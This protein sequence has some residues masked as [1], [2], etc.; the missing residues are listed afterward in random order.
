MTIRN[1]KALGDFLLERADQPFIWGVRDCSLFAA[2]A[3]YKMIGVDIASEFRGQYHD[4]KSAFRLIKKVTGGTT[5]A[6]AAAWCA[7]QYDLKEWPNPKRA[8]RGDLAI[9]ENAG[10][11][12]AG[13]V[14]L[15]GSE[16][17]ALAESGLIRI[18]LTEIKRAWRVSDSFPG[19]PSHRTKT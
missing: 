5:V 4:E 8:Q 7:D 1:L 15:N 17:I 14:H 10:R 19:N 2:D 18:P 16:V 12:I 13:I 11:L 6:D 3:I 9:V